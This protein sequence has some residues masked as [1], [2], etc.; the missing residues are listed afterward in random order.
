MLGQRISAS[1]GLA[2]PGQR[3]LARALDERAERRSLTGPS[4]GFH[5]GPQRV[6]FGGDLRQPGSEDALDRG[7][8]PGLGLVAARPAE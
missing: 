2:R 6:S 5:L 1:L 3:L 7:D 4:P 8:R